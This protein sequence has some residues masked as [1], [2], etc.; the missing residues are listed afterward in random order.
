MNP[1]TK[2]ENIWIEPKWKESCLYVVRTEP[3]DRLIDHQNVE[4][5]KKKYDQEY[6]TLT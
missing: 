3:I 1:T 5:G 6:E 2:V 4:S